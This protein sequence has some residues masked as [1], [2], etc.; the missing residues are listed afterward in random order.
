MPASAS[1][2]CSSASVSSPCTTVTARCAVCR[3]ACSRLSPPL[4]ASESA[5]ACCSRTPPL[6][7]DRAA[8]LS[9]GASFVWFLEPAGLFKLPATQDFNALVLFAVISIGIAYLSGAMRK[10]QVAERW[11]ALEWRTTLASIGDDCKACH[12][13]FRN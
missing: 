9:A 7:R 3:C 6:R 13:D 12:Q 4:S 1:P 10:A 2:S 8:V 5:F 11:A